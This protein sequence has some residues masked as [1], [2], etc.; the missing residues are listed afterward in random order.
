[1]INTDNELGYKMHILL[2]LKQT[3]LQQNWIKKIYDCWLVICFVLA[4]FLF[5]GKLSEQV[6]FQL[7][8]PIIAVGYFVRIIV[9]L[10]G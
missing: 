2:E 5:F 6:F 4:I 8:W 1:L 10:K 3:F 9:Y 7:L